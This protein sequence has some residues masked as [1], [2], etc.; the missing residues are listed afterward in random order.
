MTAGSGIA[1]SGISIDSRSEL[2]GVQLWPVLPD[3]QQSTKPSFDHYEDVPAFEWKDIGIRLFIGDFLGHTSPATIFSP[4][5]G[6]EIA[7][8]GGEPFDEEIVMW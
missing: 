4:V 5:I 3:H 6:A 1:H 7:L 8:L 2:P